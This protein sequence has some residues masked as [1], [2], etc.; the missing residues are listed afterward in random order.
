[1]EGRSGDATNILAMTTEICNERE[2]KKSRFR[3]TDSKQLRPSTAH[4]FPVMSNIGGV[5]SLVVF[6]TIYIESEKTPLH[7]VLYS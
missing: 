6:S 1:M 2:I 7:P 5:W 4:I 3:F